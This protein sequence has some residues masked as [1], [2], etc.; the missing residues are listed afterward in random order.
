MTPSTHRTPKPKV[1][2][3]ESSAQQ[4]S[5]VI[6]LCIPQRRSTRLTPPTP[7]PTAAEVEDMTIQDIIQLSIAEQKSRDDFE[8]Q[9][10][11][12]KVKEHL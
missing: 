6:R 3:E 4:N 7:I 10:N 11:E 2:K 9:K 8:A 5:T 12:E 1:S